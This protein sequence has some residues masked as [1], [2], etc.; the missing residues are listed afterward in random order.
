MV[1]VTAD[2]ISSDSGIAIK[3]RIMTPFRANAAARTAFFVPCGKLVSVSLFSQKEQLEAEMHSN[4]LHICLY[5]IISGHPAACF[6][7][8][9]SQSIAFGTADA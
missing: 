3:S 6:M 1:P 9:S 8:R 4:C 2:F 5:L 7:M